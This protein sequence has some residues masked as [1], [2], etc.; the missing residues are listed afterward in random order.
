M[1]LLRVAFVLVLL[2]LTGCSFVATYNPDFA[3]DPPAIE[4]RLPGK[5]LV[6]MTRE[7]T[8]Y[9][10]SGNPTS[11]TGGGTSLSIELGEITHRLAV[12]A[13]GSIF[14][15]GAEHADTLGD[16]SDYTVVVKPRV[17]KYTYAYNQLKNIGLAITPQVDLDIEVRVLDGAGNSLLDKTYASGTRDGN[18]YML[19]GSPGEKISEV[20]HQTIAELLNQ[21]AQDTYT[22]LK[23][24]QTTSRQ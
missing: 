18:T 5:A 20:T 21:A 3:G 16:V 24:V 23:A 6:Y 17:S 11:L 12:R 22:A 19:S 14:S 2:N 13:F 9:S 8:E 4:T 1:A 7:E 15:Q 10:F